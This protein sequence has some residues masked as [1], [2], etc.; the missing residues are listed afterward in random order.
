MSTV[1]DYQ[2]RTV[3]LAAFQGW[4]KGVGVETL[5][6]QSLAEPGE[7]GEVVTGIV[8]LAQRFLVLLLT[9][10]GSLDYLPDAGCTFMTDA[11]KGGWRTSADVL[12]SF[13][14]ALLDIK[15][16]LRSVEL[17]GDPD[18]EKFAGVT[19]LGIVLSPRDRAV[20]RLALTSQAGTKRAFI[21]PIDVATN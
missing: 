13:H 1:V 12:Q 3:D 21:A 7:G 11:R 15:R 4:E 5:L 2:G 6:D 10:R 18:D 20:L 14:F 9:E 16:Q 19:V 17:D 8:K